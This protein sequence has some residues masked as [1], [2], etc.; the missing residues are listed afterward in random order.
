TF[1]TEMTEQDWK[2]AIDTLL[3]E[4]TDSV[5]ESAM[6]EQ[7]KEIRNFAA[8]RIIKEL[9]EKRK[10]FREDMMKYY[11]HIS[12][13]VSI[14]GSNQK[15]FIT[16]TKMDEGKVDVIMNASDDNGNSGAKMYERVFYPDVTKEIRI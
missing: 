1:L 2:L 3:M 4:M 15:E 16:I 11:R 10:Y 8:V 12:R 7:P 5:I 6:N 9:K 14:V 13:T